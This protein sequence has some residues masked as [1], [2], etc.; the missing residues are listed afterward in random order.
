M[1]G[2]RATSRSP[3]GPATPTTPS[4]NFKK[5]PKRMASG[6]SALLF[7]DCFAAPVAWFYRRDGRASG[8]SQGHAK[9]TAA[10]DQPVSPSARLESGGLVPLGRRGVGEGGGRGQ[11]GAG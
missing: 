8:V 11:A 5:F 1:R 9:P 7:P 4:T 3:A 6:P 10:R 2:P